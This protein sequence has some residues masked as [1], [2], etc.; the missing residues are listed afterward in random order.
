M[1]ALL[2]IVLALLASTSAQ[3]DSRT[4]ILGSEAFELTYVADPDSRRQGLM[5]VTELPFGSGMLFDFPAGTR[6]AIWMRNMQISLD[7]VFVDNRGQIRQ[8]FADVPPCA[9]LPCALYQAD[10][11]LRWVIELPAGSVARLGL[12]VGATLDVS[13]LPATPPAL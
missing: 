13:G 6:P 11:P 10:A 5:G 7:L 12:S 4:L 3:A 8:V 2:P 9:E 1:K